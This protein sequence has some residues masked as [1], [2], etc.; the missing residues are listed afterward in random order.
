VTYGEGRE[1]ILAAAVRVFARK[2]FNATRVADVA[3]EAGVGYGLVYHYF[4]SK[5][6][7]LDT[8]FEDRWSLLVERIAR[9]RASASSSREKLVAVAG[10]IFESYRREPELMQVLITEVTRAATTFGR[11]HFER[12][13]AAYAEIAGIVADAQGSGEAPAALDPDFVAVSFFGVVE[14]VLS[15]WIFGL[16]PP[17]DGRSADAAAAVGALLCDGLLV[18]AQTACEEGEA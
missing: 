7:L 12:I 14:Q 17:F 15:G 6:E 2:G 16:L 1:R 13:A 9:I 5:D 10:F 3:G 18:A 4:R 8:I 11:R